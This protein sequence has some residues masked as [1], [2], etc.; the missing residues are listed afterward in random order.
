MDSSTED[1]P[2]SMLYLVLIQS[3]PFASKAHNQH[4]TTTQQH[5][6]SHNTTTTQ[7]NT[8]RRAHCHLPGS[9][10]LEAPK[11]RKHEY[12]AEQEEQNRNK[13]TNLDDI[14]SLK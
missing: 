7:H 5:N 12:T 13:T 4:V 6:F 8:Y 11:A 9:L 3:D 1:D 14:A 10:N 2:T